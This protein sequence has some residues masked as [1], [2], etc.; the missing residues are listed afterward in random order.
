[1]EDPS[2]DG[3]GVLNV[4]LSRLLFPRM[5]PFVL[6]AT[7]LGMF[8]RA[9]VASAQTP[10]GGVVGVNMK[11]LVDKHNRFQGDLNKLRDELRTASEALAAAREKIAE[12]AR[13]LQESG[14]RPG[15]REFID[16]EQAI[17][18]EQ[19]EWQIKAKTQQRAIQTREAQLLRNVYMEVKNEV[20]RYAT[21]H[22]VAVVVQFVPPEPDSDNRGEIQALLT[23]PIVHVNDHFDITHAVLTSLNRGTA[24]VT[25]NNNR[26]SA[27]QVPS[28]PR[29]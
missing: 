29:R 12:R 11:Y 19:A 6:L 25:P 24:P 17:A 3:K 5:I 15:S 18:R 10:G 13:K 28:Q 9:E 8:L 2:P 26:P 1:M 27:A 20:A 21:Q 16:M 4:K 23:H 7:T 22:R 14:L